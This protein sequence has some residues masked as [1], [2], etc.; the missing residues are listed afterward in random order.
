MKHRRDSLSDDMLLS[1]V[2][3]VVSMQVLASRR[4]VHRLNSGVLD[5]GVLFAAAKPKSHAWSPCPVPSSA[6]IRMNSALTAQ[7]SNQPRATP[8]LSVDFAGF[9]SCGRASNALEKSSCNQYISAKHTFAVYASSRYFSSA[10]AAS[11]SFGASS[12]RLDMFEEVLELVVL[13]TAPTCAAELAL[14][15]RAVL[16]Y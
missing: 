10:D 9:V 11:V 5:P 1:V 4:S 2:R 12:P 13:E 3:R 14:S 6:A 7:T 15:A 16:R 8:R